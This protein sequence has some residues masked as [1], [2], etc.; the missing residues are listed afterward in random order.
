M[1]AKQ[2]TAVPSRHRHRHWNTRLHSG[3]AVVY[4]INQRSVIA[5][6]VTDDRRAGRWVAG[7]MAARRLC[8]GSQKLQ[9]AVRR[10]R[11]VLDPS[12]SS[13]AGH[14]PLFSV[15]MA[16]CILLGSILFRRRSTLAAWRPGGF[17]ST[18]SQL[19]R[20]SP[21]DLFLGREAGPGSLAAWLPWLGTNPVVYICRRCCR[22]QSQDFGRRGSSMGAGTSALPQACDAPGK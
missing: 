11:P 9:S 1:P 13:A 6:P 16:M 7:H 21:Q 12:T 3:S 4:A 2:P 22:P 15:D 14:F 10:Q 19:P 5:G 18:P 8:I 17:R 20:L